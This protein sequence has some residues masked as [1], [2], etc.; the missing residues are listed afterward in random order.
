[1]AIYFN[2]FNI[3]ALR[4]FTDFVGLTA[5]AAG[6][7]IGISKLYDAFSDPVMGVISDRTRS[8]FGRR[9]PYV[10]LGGLMCAFSIWFVFSAPEGMSESAAFWY[11]AAGVI[12]YA[13]SYTVYN[14]PYMAMPAEIT[15]DTGQRSSMMSWRVVCIGIGG[16]VA[17][18]VGPKIVEWNGGGMQ[19]HSSMGMVLGGAI[20]CFTLLMTFMTRGATGLTVV[21]A[22]KHTP[23]RD[24]VATV[25][26]NGP[27]LLLL[28]LKLFLLCAIAISS[29]TSA[30]FIVW[31]LK[32]NYSDLGT[33][34]LVTSVGQIIGAPLWLRIQKRAGSRLTFFV[35]AGVYAVVCMTW[36]LADAQEAFEITLVRVFL[37]GIAA[38]GILLVGQALLPDT[39][40]YDRLRTGLRREGI[41]SGMY[42][43][44]EK[45]SFAIGAAMTG[46]YLGAAGYV[47]KV[48]PVTGTQPEEAITAIYFCQSVLPAALVC[49]A[50]CF[51]I[52]Y[53]LDGNT[54]AVMREEELPAGA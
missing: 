33:I 28:G 8:R 45:L 31:I 11:V 15:T 47:A 37:K 44:I 40:E 35:S 12:L 7:L 14:I 5:A 13:T 43:T 36:L 9:R 1:M 21:P 4:Y 16:L 42:T 50:A 51:M 48:N 17:G 30:F 34:V 38:G 22:I 25:L 54:L 19:G 41:L 46:L 29:A 10:L 52:F 6:F 2:S 18:T 20:V 53:R 27:F 3:L 23:F 26:S 24:K 32:L 39:I 49:I